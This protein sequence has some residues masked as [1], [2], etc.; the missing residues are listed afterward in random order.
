MAIPV[1]C[2]SENRH[3]CRA[4]YL[5]LI[6][7]K[8]RSMRNYKALS[9]LLAGYEQKRDKTGQL[10]T[11]RV[12]LIEDECILLGKE[13]RKLPTWRF[14]QGLLSGS[15]MGFGA[16]QAVTLTGVV[17]YPD[18]AALI[19]NNIAP[20]AA[21][22]IFAA[23][24]VTTPLR[25]LFTKRRLINHVLNTGYRTTG[26]FFCLPKMSP[27]AIAE[28]SKSTPASPQCGLKHG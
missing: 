14:M 13:R 25:G 3:M 27:E 23:T 11:T 1:C 28:R 19:R 26:H 20:L 15:L 2:N 7:G 16:Y 9:S 5:N 8:L 10:L 4:F 24:I 6:R 21:A 18:S 22:F 17:A 12:P